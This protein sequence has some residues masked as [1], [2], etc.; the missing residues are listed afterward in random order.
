METVNYTEPS[1]QT[2]PQCHQAVSP[3]DVFCPH[4]G[5]QLKEAELKISLITQLWIYFVS[6]FLPP[7]GFWPGIKYYRNSDPKAQQ[8]GM[9]AIILSVVST[10]GTLWLTYEFLNIYLST[11]SQIG[12]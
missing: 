5:K 8:I 12:Y 7:L 6:L 3:T 2:C 9:I 10:V 1:A 4:C 11:F